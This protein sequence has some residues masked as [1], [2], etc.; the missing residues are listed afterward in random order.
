M[1]SGK[2]GTAPVRLDKGFQFVNVSPKP[3]T[4]VAAPPQGPAK[5]RE[6]WLLQG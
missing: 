2:S 3:R 1:S 5:M 4:V 6:P